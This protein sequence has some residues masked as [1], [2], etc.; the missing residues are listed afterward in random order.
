MRCYS[1]QHAKIEQFWVH[2]GPPAQLWLSLFFHLP[3]QVRSPLLLWGFSLLSNN[4]FWDQEWPS[5]REFSNRLLL[6]Y[7]LWFSPIFRVFLAFVYPVEVMCG[8]ARL[9]RRASIAWKMCATI[10]LVIGQN[11]ITNLLFFAIN[12]KHRLLL[13]LYFTFWN[14]C[15]SHLFSFLYI[16]DNKSI[17]L[18]ILIPA[19]VCL[20]STG[21]KN[22]SSRHFSTLQRDFKLYPPKLHSKLTLTRCILFPRVPAFKR[23][24]LRLSSCCSSTN[25]SL[26]GSTILS[27]NRLI[28]AVLTAMSLTLPG[29]R[30][31]H[32]QRLISQLYQRFFSQNCA[33]L[34]FF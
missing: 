8:T 34:I 25:E 31:Y 19:Y 11:K 3:S 29:W 22:T 5:S 26:V 9:L 13:E 27:T 15:E 20:F 1:D 7:L 21:R 16:I 12:I 14:F 2:S 6:G 32:S 30:K 10:K 28:L 33:I 24:P 17:H 4:P 18:Q 23:M